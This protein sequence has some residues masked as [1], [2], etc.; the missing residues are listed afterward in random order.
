MKTKTLADGLPQT[1]VA[2]Q[3]IDNAAV[4]TDNS[5]TVKFG[6]GS[7]ESYAIYLIV[8]APIKNSITKV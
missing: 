3:T 5:G 8:T 1:E 4:S 7:D 2:A 6:K